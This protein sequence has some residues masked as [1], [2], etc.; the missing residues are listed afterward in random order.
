MRFLK[1]HKREDFNFSDAQTRK[2]VDALINMEYKDEQFMKLVN[3]VFY[4]LDS[5]SKDDSDLINKTYDYLEYLQR[6]VKLF[7]LAHFESF[8]DHQQS[9]KSHYYLPLK[10]IAASLLAGEEENLIIKEE[11]ISEKSRQ[12]YLTQPFYKEVILRLFQLSNPS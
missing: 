1:Y 3:K 10:L 8:L 12:F 2:I 11:L 6:K 9:E 7:S 5:F 4:S